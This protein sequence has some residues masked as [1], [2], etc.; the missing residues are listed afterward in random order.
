MNGSASSKEKTAGSFSP[1]LTTSAL[2]AQATFGQPNMLFPQ[3]PQQQAAAAQFIRAQWA[4]WAM[5]SQQFSTSHLHTATATNNNSQQLS[6]VTAAGFL[7]FAPPPPPQRPGKQK[8]PC[9]LCTLSDCGAVSFV[10]STH[11]P[12]FFPPLSPASTVSPSLSHCIR[13]ASPPVWRLPL[14]PIIHFVES[15][16]CSLF[17]SLQIRR[18]PLTPTI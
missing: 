6:A 17:S 14:F 15:D 12:R 5:L 11:T 8:S 3:Y 7:P 2:M 9:S 18:R 4:Q 16:L 13:N 1:D 10:F